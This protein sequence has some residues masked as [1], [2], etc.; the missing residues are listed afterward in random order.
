MRTTPSSFVTSLVLA[1]ALT[2][3]PARAQ[4]NV[5][6]EASVEV[7]G[8]GEP[9][10][11]EG[12]E[13]DP[14]PKMALAADVAAG[15][16]VGGFG[17]Y[18]GF[19]LGV[20]L[21]FEYD[22]D[23]KLT[24]TARAGYLHHLAKERDEAGSPESKVSELPILG[25]VKVALSGPVYGA[26]EFGVD[27]VSVDGG[28]AVECVEVDNHFALTAGGGYEMGDIDLRAALVVAD[29]GEAGD[30]LMLLAG[31]GVVFSRF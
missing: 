13:E 22:I 21:R 15:L 10:E 12:L 2:S 4:V 24:A 11:D 26:L 17:D 27:H 5:G 20:L 31:A 29:L 8:P 6:G 3:S 16:P 23:T 19:A 25:G 18:A 14:P 9:S 1:V 7:G 28:C 30:S